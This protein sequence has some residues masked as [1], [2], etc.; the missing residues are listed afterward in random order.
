MAISFFKKA[1]NALKTTK[2]AFSG[3]DATG[4]TPDILLTPEMSR[5][6]LYDA[7]GIPVA[8]FYLDELPHAFEKPDDIRVLTVAEM[9]T[10]AEW[11][12]PK[13]LAIP[14]PEGKLFSKLAHDPTALVS[15]TNGKSAQTWI[16]PGSPQ[17][18]SFLRSGASLPQ[19]LTGSHF[20]ACG[21]LFASDRRWTDKQDWSHFTCL[22]ENL[23][24][25]WPDN[26][27]LKRWTFAHESAHLLQ[28]R[29]SVSTLQD[30]WNREYDADLFANEQ[31]RKQG[32]DHE[33]LAAITLAR[34]LKGF[35]AE[36]DT[37][38]TALALDAEANGQ[39]I[40]SANARMAAALALKSGVYTSLTGKIA[41][42]SQEV[43]RYFS[44]EQNRH[45][46]IPALREFMDAPEIKTTDALR[47]IGVVRTGELVMEAARYFCPT[48]AAA[49][50]AQMPDRPDA[51]QDGTQTPL[52]PV[53]A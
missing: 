25:H 31:M 17:C 19:R 43:G 20:P 13:L 15:V 27:S 14:N 1:A 10:R 32:I 53:P 11:L 9:V 28:R 23:I 50:L 12:E 18:L 45:L 30:Q 51:H 37:H 33:N 26:F 42:D 47:R 44:N 16:G 52:V 21:I 22:A 36:D 6:D 35:L 4:K 29:S 40:P 2:A 7:L 39:P 41:E 48:M 34:A 46:L 38:Q 5:A 3:K 49:P 8:R 24:E